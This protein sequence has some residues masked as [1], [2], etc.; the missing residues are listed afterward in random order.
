VLAYV[1]LVV[2]LFG[3]SALWAELVSTTQGPWIPTPL[4]WRYT[5]QISATRYG[6]HGRC[7]EN[8]GLAAASI[9]IA[10]TEKL[11]ALALLSVAGGSGRHWDWDRLLLQ[12][13]YLV[14]DELRCDALSLSLLGIT[15][16]GSKS[17]V[18]TAA[19]FVPANANFEVGVSAGREFSRSFFWFLR[20]WLSGFAGIANVGSPWLRGDVG[21]GI[22]PSCGWQMWARAEA[23]K[24]YGSCK[25]S[26]GPF[27]GY[28]RLDAAWVDLGVGI[29]I[30]R[31]WGQLKAGYW[32]RLYESG[33]P[34]QQTGIFA[35]TLTRSF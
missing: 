12:A 21:F 10:P 27:P 9:A 14:L 33:A 18:Q 20:G 17:A 15:Y 3:T 28:A 11:D 34:K 8:L 29:E 2:C 1:G 30:A 7:D 32:Y 19:E 26:S 24:T 25:Y 22:Q 16:L 13:R 35:V 5:G 4:V 23:L 31:I 6:W